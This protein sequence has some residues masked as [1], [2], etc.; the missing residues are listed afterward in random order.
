MNAL[1]PR[2]ADVASPRW[3]ASL[4]LIAVAMLCATLLSY[5]VIL[6]ALKVSPLLLVPGVGSALLARFGRAFW[7]A[8]AVGDVVGQVIMQDRPLGIVTLSVL[9]HVVACL[10]CATWLQRSGC[11][12]RDLGQATRFA[13]ISAVVSIAGAALT[14]SLLVA[15][16]DIP[17]Q[18]GVAEAG[19]WLLMGYMAG[20][21]VGGAFVLA[22]GDP[23]L[24][25]SAAVRHPVAMAAF[26]G[27]TTCAGVGLLGEIGPLV[28]VALLGA[29]AV[30]GRSGARWATA[31]MLAIGIITIAALVRGM[32]PPFGGGDPAEQAANAMLALSLFAAAAIMLAGYRQAGPARERSA[33]AVAVVFAALMMVAGITSLAANEVA[34]NRTTPYVLSGLLALGAAAGL[35]VL[36]ISRTPATPST[37]RGV[38]LALGAGAVYV[39]NLALYLQA[40]PEIGSGPA[41]GLA[42]TAPLWIM[43]L[44]MLA[45]R[46]RPTWGVVVA[47]AL[48][49]AGAV[50]IA[51]EATANPA[52][53]ALALGSAAVFAGSV[54][55][56]KQAL[57]HAN[58][59]DVALASALAA[60]LVA[61][62]IGVVTEGLDA[63][64]LTAAE[65]GALALA[66]LGAQ[67]VPTL[68]RSWALS[69]ISADV[70][71][72]EGVLAPVTTTVLSFW[73]LDEATTGGDVAGL[74]L[75]A[76]GAVVAALIG[77][78]RAAP[79]PAPV[80]G[81]PLPATTHA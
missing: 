63:F 3:W 45:Y 80:R 70:V 58:I 54:I 49:V 40:V 59:I 79:P 78:R 25:L 36:R 57:A 39:M 21:L 1:L 9:V 74:M 27:V 29:I 51:A 6:T 28:P 47:V 10:A 44:G 18:Y 81:Q 69:H 11:W 26:V 77:S 15:V 41:T 14:A 53:V 66:A 46:T 56:T 55:I 60:A 4:G 30:A 48:I 34:M 19:G 2:R 61:L 17:P 43:G 71:G 13:G 67:L 38:A 76:T 37:R 52:G 73:F 75:I 62:A 22:W 20:F 5:A 7:P 32:E 72:A 8:I 42:M 31:C 65:Y 24:P 33:T 35:G 23:D 64:D 16:G 68:G 12:L 50:A